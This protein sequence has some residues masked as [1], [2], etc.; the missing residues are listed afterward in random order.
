MV[1]KKVIKKCVLLFSGGLDSRLAVKIMQNQGYKVTAVF[2]KLPFGCGC[3]DAFGCSFNF[4]QMEG[5]KLEVF[6]C[7]KGD[8]LQEYMEVLKEGKNGRGAS[9]NPCRDCKIFMF[10]RAKKFADDKKIDLIVTGE[11]LGER[12]MSQMKK[13]MDLIEEQS[14]LKGRLL[15]PL[16]AK[17]LPET[18]AEKQ[19]LVDREKLYDIHGRRREKQ[20]ALA[21]KFKIK[22]PAPAGGCLLCEKFLKKRFEF[23][24]KRGIT[25]KE[26]PLTYVGRQFIINGSW[27][28]LGRDKKENDL[29]E[30]VGNNGV[31]KLITSDDVEVIGPS[32]VVLDGKVSDKK[33]H[34]LIRS[35]SK[36]G[37]LELRKN[38]EKFKL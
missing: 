35:Y 18:N 12:P 16:S 13:S 2:F 24:F 23:L 14:D 9:V 4:S 25:E 1:K 30:M 29:I 5:V 37:S 26:L 8:L 31:G 21:N 6:D 32:V 11:V 28:I 7:T 3:C 34:E 20:M 27:I 15:R 10:E 22:Y 33:I 19:G 17:L 36:E 38:F